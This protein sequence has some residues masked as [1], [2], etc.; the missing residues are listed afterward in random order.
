VSDG[1]DAGVDYDIYTRSFPSPAA[2]N[3]R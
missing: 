2:S 3:P 1:M